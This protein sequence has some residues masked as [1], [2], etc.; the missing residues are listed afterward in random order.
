M[1]T[2]GA[3]G[4]ETSVCC[5][6][7]HVSEQVLRLQAGGLGLSEPRQRLGYLGRQTG[8]CEGDLIVELR[9]AERSQRHRHGDCQR[10]FRQRHVFG[11]IAQQGT[12]AER[13]SGVFDCCA[14][15]TRRAP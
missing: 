8:E 11:E 12:G 6:I 1:T 10:V 4:I 2:S 15:A 9:I 3:P 13:Q 5:Q 7:A 14:P